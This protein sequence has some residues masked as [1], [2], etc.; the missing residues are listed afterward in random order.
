MCECAGHVRAGPATQHAL[1]LR[2]ST[3]QYLILQCAS[4][5]KLYTLP[6][7]VNCRL[8]KSNMPSHIAEFSWL[9]MAT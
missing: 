5:G 8:S 6:S 3:L 4:R 2:T 7:L 1:L 9:M